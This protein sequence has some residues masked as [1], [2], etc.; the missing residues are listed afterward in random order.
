MGPWTSSFGGC[1]LKNLIRPISFN[2]RDISFCY[3]VFLE[4]R[5][6][7]ITDR[8]VK[9]NW[10]TV[11]ISKTQIAIRSFVGTSANAWPAILRPVRAVS[12]SRWNRKPV[13]TSLLLF[14]RT[15]NIQMTLATE[16]SARTIVSGI[17]SRPHRR[18]DNA[19]AFTLKNLFT[20]QS[21]DWYVAGR[22]NRCLFDG[23]RNK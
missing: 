14:I 18:L 7:A 23:V 19:F 6:F 20:E 12:H 17:H 8:R 22:R 21:M 2:M 1:N 3:L 16:L 10:K 5:Y 4:H 9:G 13:V 15:S 11:S